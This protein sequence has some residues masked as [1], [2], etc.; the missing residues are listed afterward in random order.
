[1]ASVYFGLS[2]FVEPQRSAEK[3]SYASLVTSTLV[4]A[5]SVNYFDLRN[6]MGVIVG[7]SGSGKT[8]LMN[9][10]LGQVSAQLPCHSISFHG[11]LK[12][13]QYQNQGYGQYQQPHEIIQLNKG[14]YSINLFD[15]PAGLPKEELRTFASV[16]VDRMGLPH[17]G[18]RQRM[19]LVDGVLTTLLASGTF[20]EVGN[21]ILHSPVG[22]EHVFNEMHER[23]SAS[24]N[25][26]ESEVLASVASKLEP[27]VN[28]G[29]FLTKNFID[30]KELLN[31]S[32]VYDLSNVDRAYQ[33]IVA[34]TIARTVM[35]E[36]RARHSNNPPNA[37]RL[38]LAVD[39]VQI[40]LGNDK[41]VLEQAFQ[42][43]RKFGLGMLVAT[44]NYS[45]LENDHISVMNN[46]SLFIAL[47]NSNRKEVRKISSDTGLWPRFIQDRGF[48][49][50]GMKVA[51]LDV[52]YTCLDMRFEA[53]TNPEI[54]YAHNDLLERNRW[55]EGERRRVQNERQRT[56]MQ[57]EAQR[58][59]MAIASM[60]QPQPQYG[61]MQP[62]QF[63]PVSHSGSVPSYVS[64][65]APK[66][67]AF[68]TSSAVK[69]GVTYSCSEG[70]AFFDEHTG[71]PVAQADGD[72][73][74]AEACEDEE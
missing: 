25:K 58:K 38:I 42:E 51:F 68:R 57:Q 26:T 7:A 61:M 35:R 67:L 4:G 11:D 43:Y 65:H 74:D 2:H 41:G 13:T 52:T 36:L 1:M 71:A 59:Q 8:T 34:S 16:C 21:F 9:L 70:V 69:D 3:K 45:S 62:Q 73:F 56:A 47:S 40:L 29:V 37:P 27:L 54:V 33:G 63:A 50:G 48:L 28:S 55:Q 14:G 22:I 60:Q 23:Y 30:V 31:R 39:E 18:S 20:D 46:A 24:A 5:V 53:I 6:A 72:V 32:C 15:V 64:S 19:A 17:L 12:P 49:Q 10:I 66:L 44:Q